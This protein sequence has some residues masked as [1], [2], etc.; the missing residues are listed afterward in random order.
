MQTHKIVAKKAYRDEIM[1]GTL[2]F[3]L[4][5]ILFISLLG[6]ISA[7]A[8]AHGHGWHRW[9][10]RAC[11]KT[12]SAALLACQYEA[13]DDKWIAIGKCNNLEDAGER[14][15]CLG[16]AKDEFNEAKELCKEQF[17][18]RKEVCE[19]VGE[20]PYD[21]D[22]ANFTYRPFPIPEDE[23]NPYLPLK[24]GNKWVY[25]GGDETITVEVLRKTKLIEGVTCIVVNDVVEECDEDGE[26]CT[27]IEDTDD[28]YAQKI[29]GDVWYFGEIARDFETFEGDAPEE[30]ELVDIGGSWKTGRDGA[31]PGM[32][33][34]KEPQLGHAYRQEM[35][36]GEAED[37]AEVLSNN[38]VFNGDDENPESLDYK[39]PEKLA[40]M[41]CGTVPENS[42]C[43]VTRDF[44]ALEP[45]V[46]ERKYY[47]PGIG[48]F[49]EVNLET[50]EIVQLVECN[51]DPKCSSLP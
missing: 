8:L 23:L 38:Y 4:T 24:V 27:V 26:E 42:Q 5:I 30:P 16:E 22:F 51:V 37:L 49:L 32:L 25:E 2:P 11:S 18:A 29:N 10:P 21:P 31:K 19:L 43:V 9:Q 14:E 46:E 34:A 35:S 12:S 41:L 45:G 1:R 7:P 17:E 40:N 28:W 48:V 44:T 3:G 36:L 13:K 39:V 33:I 15:E 20:D 47:A 6:L 50:G